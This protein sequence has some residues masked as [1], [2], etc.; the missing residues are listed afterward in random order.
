MLPDWHIVAS[1]SGFPEMGPTGFQPFYRLVISYKAI[2]N[3]S[4]YLIELLRT[5]E[6]LKRVRKP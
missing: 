2:A 3:G 5:Y 1:T 4:L 6:E